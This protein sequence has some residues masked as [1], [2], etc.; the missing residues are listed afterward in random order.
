MPLVP[1]FAAS[2]SY[3]TPS[4]ITLTDSS[5][6]SDVDLAERRVFIQDYTGAYLKESGQE[7]NYKVWALASSSVELDLLTRDKAVKITVTYVNL[8]GTTLYTAIQYKCCDANSQIGKY[9]VL[10]KWV[11]NPGIIN[12]ANYASGIVLLETYMDGAQDAIRIGSNLT[13]SQQCL[14]GAKNMLDN[15][16]IYF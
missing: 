14:D 13:L 9:S 2:Q 3:A 10:Q 12:D 16:S 5:T 1:N 11:S 7:A 15:Q 6:G 4:K 8:A